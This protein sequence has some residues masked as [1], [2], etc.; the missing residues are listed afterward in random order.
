[1]NNGKQRQDR[2]EWHKAS[3]QK[4]QTVHLEEVLY[5]KRGQTLG[6]AS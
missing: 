2:Q 5:Y 1:M 4:V 3:K 6:Q